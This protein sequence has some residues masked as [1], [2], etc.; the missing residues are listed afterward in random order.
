MGAWRAVGDIVNIDRNNAGWKPRRVSSAMVEAGAH[1]DT[2]TAAGNARS[3]KNCSI[4]S[5]SAGDLSSNVTPS[6]RL[7]YRPAP[8]AIAAPPNISC[9][10][11]G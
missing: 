8:I 11:A 2:S 1:D 7:T 9:A 5:M 3:A 4:A 10:A 6:T